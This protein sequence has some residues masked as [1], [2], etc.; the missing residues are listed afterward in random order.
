MT[1]IPS[2]VTGNLLVKIEPFQ[3][4]DANAFTGERGG[5]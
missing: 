3:V 2:T 1:G 5:R 4:Y